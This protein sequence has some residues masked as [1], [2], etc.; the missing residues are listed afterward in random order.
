VASGFNCIAH[1]VEA[2]YAENA[3]PITSL[4]AE[5]GIRA[6]TRG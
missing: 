4:M 5:E 1:A 6:L 2:L 3:N